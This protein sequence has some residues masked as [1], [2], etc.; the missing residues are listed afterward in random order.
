[1]PHFLDEIFLDGIH[2]ISGLPVG[3]EYPVSGKS[4]VLFAAPCT[5]K[6]KG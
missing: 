5:Y 6:V 1:M 4:T 2:G 3:F